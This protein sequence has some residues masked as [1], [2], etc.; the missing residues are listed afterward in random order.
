MY[1]TE[2]SVNDSH[3][4]TCLLKP[5]FSSSTKVAYTPQGNSVRVEYTRQIR[6]NTTDCVICEC[7][8][9]MRASAVVSV[10]P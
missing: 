10:G 4:P 8:H 6:R 1:D 5:C 3:I 2:P 7:M 9:Q